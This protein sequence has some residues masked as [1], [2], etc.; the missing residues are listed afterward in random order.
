MKM[1]DASGAITV[2]DL[3][4][5]PISVGTTVRY[6]TTRTTGKVIG[7]KEDEGRKWALVDS[8]HLFY[9][10]R[11]LEV[12][13]AKASDEEDE[14]VAKVDVEDLEKRIKAMEDALK[15]KDVYTDSSC[16]GGG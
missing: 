16:E 3:Y 12:T 7:L 10:T 8:T 11:Y 13:Q 6:V 4:G 14:K 9:D 2:T 1:E 15:V 5:K